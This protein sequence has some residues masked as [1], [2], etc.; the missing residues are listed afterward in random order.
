MQHALDQVGVTAAGNGVEEAAGD[1]GPAAGEITGGAQ[2]LPRLPGTGRG[3]EDNTVNAAV[4]AQDR[5]GQSTAAAAH[6]NERAENA[7][8]VAAKQ[9]IDLTT[10][11]VPRERVQLF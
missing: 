4:S 1:H 3:V 11:G 7:E 5:G 2:P 9:A 6:V 10:C 8:I